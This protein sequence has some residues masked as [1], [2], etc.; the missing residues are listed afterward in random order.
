MASWLWKL[1][2]VDNCR[3]CLRLAFMDVLQKE[4][5]EIVVDWNSHYVR[6]QR[7]LTSPC[8]IPEKLFN[9]PELYGNTLLFYTFIIRYTLTMIHDPRARIAV[10][11]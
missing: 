6:K 4:L 10:I 3:K 9:L 2:I 7:H 5:D 11:V 8:G 1:I